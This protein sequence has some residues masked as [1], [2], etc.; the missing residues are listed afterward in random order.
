M[1][2][3]FELLDSCLIELSDEDMNETYGGESLWYWIAY[4]TGYAVG[5]AKAFADGA[6]YSAREMPGLK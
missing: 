3:N 5:T 4:G 1:K 6:A 2:N